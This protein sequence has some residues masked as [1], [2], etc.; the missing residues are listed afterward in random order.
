M[1]SRVISRDLARSCA[2]L[3][4]RSRAA[5]RRHAPPR[6]RVRSR[7]RRPPRAGKRR[8]APAIKGKWCGRVQCEVSDA[9]RVG[10]HLVRTCRVELLQIPIQIPSLIPSLIPSQILDVLEE[11]RGDRSRA[12]ARRP[13]AHAALDRLAAARCVCEGPIS[14]MKSCMR[15]M[16]INASCEV[17]LNHEDSTCLREYPTAFDTCDSRR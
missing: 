11:P 12:R 10:G 16:I 2:Y 3:P 7:P 15:G 5:A 8:R 4:A 17:R 13:H 6:R 14:M 9:I 1:R